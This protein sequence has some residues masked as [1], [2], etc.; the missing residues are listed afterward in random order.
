MKHLLLMR[1]AKSDWGDSSLN[2]HDRPL[3][4][5]GQRDAPRMGMLLESEGLVPDMIVSSTARRA[6]ETAEI[7]AQ[8]CGYSGEIQLQPGLYHATPSQWEEAVSELPDSQGTILMVGH[9][10]GIEVFQRLLSGQLQ[11]FPTATIAA[12]ALQTEKW[13]DFRT[14]SVTLEG[15]FRPKEL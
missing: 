14:S 9:N 10:P 12:L 6:R 7:V 5:R 13:T 8:N 1:H 2:D 4:P 3:N 11:P 15:V